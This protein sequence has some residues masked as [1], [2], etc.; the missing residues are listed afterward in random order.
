MMWCYYMND[1]D[2]RSI[3]KIVEYCQIMEDDIN[4]F[5][6]FDEY[7]SNSLYQRAT[8]F[9]IKRYEKYSCS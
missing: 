6:D 8:A 5:G 9:N 2:R 3:E 7:V 4:K 1:K